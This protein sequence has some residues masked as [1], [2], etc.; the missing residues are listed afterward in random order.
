[1]PALKVWDGATWQYVSGPPGANGTNGIDG[2]GAGAIQSKTANYTALSTDGIILADASSGA[3]TITLPAVAVGE[4]LIVKK[5][6]SS[7][8]YVTVSPA[9][10]TI[11]GDASV[12][13]GVQWRSLT[14]VSNGTNWFLI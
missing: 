14:F 3:F 7:V 10:G 4:S 6:D 9:S 8:N 2:F 12:I 13:I 1:M 11:D 5:I